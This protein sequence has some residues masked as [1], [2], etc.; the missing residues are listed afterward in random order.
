MK[1]DATQRCEPDRPLDENALVRVLEDTIRRRGRGEQVSDEV[2]IDAHR[3]LMPELGEQL[4]AL[5]QVEQAEFLAG[6]TTMGSGPS[7]VSEVAYPGSP[8]SLPNDF[9][10]GYEL[11]EEIHQGGQGVVYK[12][13]Q[14]ATKRTVALKVLLAGPFSSARQRHRFEREIDLVAGLEHPNIVTLYDSGVTQDDRHY[15]AMEYIHGT[16]LNAYLSEKAFSVE[17]TLRLF[18]KICVAVNYAHQH[19]VIHR[20]LKPGNICI[21]ADGEPHV[22]DFGLAK[23][24]GPDLSSGVPV[25]LTGEF[26][27]TL[28]YASPE[29]TQGDPKLIDIRSDVYSLGVILYEMLTGKSPYPV[30]GRIDEVMKNIS[31]AEPRKP[32]TLIRRIKNEVETIVLKA[33]AK[34]KERRYQSAGTLSRDIEHYLAGEPIDAKRDS[35]W[36]LIHKLLRRHRV[37]IAVAAVLVIAIGFAAY[38]HNKASRAASAALMEKYYRLVFETQFGAQFEG[39]SAADM[40]ARKKLAIAD[41]T[42]AIERGVDLPAW[43]ALRAKL[44]I[45]DHQYAL[46]WHDC[47]RALE[48]DPENSLALRTR[49]YLLLERGEF[50]AALDAY[51]KGL[52][53]RRGWPEDYHN[54]GRLRR[55][56]GDYQAALDDHDRAVVMAPKEDI[57]YLGRGITRRCAGDVEGAIEDLTEVISLDLDHRGWSFQCY[58]WLWEMRSLRG[59]PGDAEAAAVA[60]AAAREAT[61][62]RKE[63]WDRLE[64]AA[65]DLFAG[66]LTP[67][68]V[69]HLA[70]NPLVRSVT[71]YYVGVKALVDGRREDAATW[72]KQCRDGLRRLGKFSPPEYDLAGCHLEQLRAE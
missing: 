40:A 69:L 68:E 7:S 32:S 12:A 21:D 39:A 26:T 27:G 31:E 72:F 56:V 58:Q 36:Y 49:G 33:L 2:V 65:S 50:A 52:R 20:D 19:G 8:P 63:P 29:Q 22:L 70:P 45:R 23:V 42:R 46:A 17:E 57:V 62:A 35:S 3:D 43:Y 25:T 15:F 48:L 67:D 41:C 11:L 47:D 18:L 53:G 38:N 37:H 14:Q 64:N 10:P 13:V 59:G 61:A 4:R 60:L 51:D 71:C 28:A 5:R 24:A 16:A 44:L 30:I 6:G 9:F 66:R 55:I 1:Y 34:E 54:R